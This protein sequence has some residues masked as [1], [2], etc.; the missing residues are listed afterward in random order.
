M[1][2]M[3]QLQAEVPHPLRDDLP[4]LLTP[5]GMTTPA[6]RV[7]LQVFG[8]LGV[9]KSAAMQIQSHHIG[10]CESLLR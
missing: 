3:A 2:L 4:A 8:G 1:K 9:F 6:I 10:S 7:L 5:G